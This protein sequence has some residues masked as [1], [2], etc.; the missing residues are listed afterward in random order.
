[1][2][3]CNY[4]HEN[5]HKHEKKARFTA[6]Q[7]SV[8]SLKTSQLPRFH[9]PTITWTFAKVP[10]TGNMRVIIDFLCAMNFLDPALDQYATAHSASEPELLKELTRETHLKTTMPRMLSGHLQGRFL[11]L[12]SKLVQPEI[13]LEIGTFT[14]YATL[15]LA[16]GL[17][18]GG[19]LITLD[20]NDETS[21]IAQKYFTKS[22]YASQIDLRITDAT[23]EIPKMEMWFD[24][25]FIDADKENYSNYFDM[26]IGKM[27]KGALIIADNV[28]W[29]GKVLHPV[30]PNDSETM[31]ITSFNEKVCADNRVEQ[32]LLPLRDGLMIL[33]VK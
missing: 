8:A 18:T 20:T 4:Q 15:C 16:E 30:K 33:R 2:Y 19:K 12:I 11:S 32:L 29:S 28:L 26:V 14:G 21:S 22:D 10:R 7:R 1:M 24:L 17:K 25:V 9:K 13:I 23:H 27:K 6:P 31:A 3:A 5:V